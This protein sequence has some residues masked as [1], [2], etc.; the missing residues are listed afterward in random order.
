MCTKV[1]Y[2]QV[3]G[4]SWQALREEAEVKENG[5]AETDKPS[6][7][8]NMHSALEIKKRKSGKESGHL[9]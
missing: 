6:L 5:M 8:K 4:W 2:K 9:R 7:L 3:L 1:E